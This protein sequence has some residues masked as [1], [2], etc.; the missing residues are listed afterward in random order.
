MNTL[1]LP[2]IC[3]RDKET[4][5]GSKG[6]NNNTATAWHCIQTGRSDKLLFEGKCNIGNKAG[7]ED[8]EIHALQEGQNNLRNTKENLGLIYL[9]VYNQ[10]ARKLLLGEQSSGLEFVR[11]GREE[12]EILRHSAARSWGSGPR[13]I[14][15][16][17]EMTQL[18]PW[19]KKASK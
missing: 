6:T 15:T 16:Y 9:C 17:P 10:K 18:T 13:H 4:E 11:K 19:P 14:K 5:D 12:I 8:G 1:P 3:L 2:T 7:I